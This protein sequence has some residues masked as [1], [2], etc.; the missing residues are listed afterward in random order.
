[1]TCID[2]PAALARGAFAIAALWTPSR[3]LGTRIVGITIAKI[4]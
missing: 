3:A 2:L 4:S 1:M